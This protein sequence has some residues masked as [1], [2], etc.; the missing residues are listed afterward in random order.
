MN[1]SPEFLRVWWFPALLLVMVIGNAIALPILTVMV[2]LLA[3]LVGIGMM[4]ALEGMDPAAALRN[5]TF[6]AAGIFLFI[7]FFVRTKE[8]FVCVGPA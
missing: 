2:G 5:V 1:R 4:K 6:I 7:M 3:S 8:M